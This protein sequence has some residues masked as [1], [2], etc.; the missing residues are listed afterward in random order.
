MRK[1]SRR[2]QTE[3][4]SGVVVT[5]GPSLLPSQSGVLV[6]GGPPLAILQRLVPAKRGV[7]WVPWSV[8]SHA[9]CQVC[10]CGVAT[11]RAVVPHSPVY[12]GANRACC[13]AA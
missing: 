10:C 5:R 7:P 9:S 13:S 1:M 3:I 12:M 2:E 6:P 11:G 4:L 8:C